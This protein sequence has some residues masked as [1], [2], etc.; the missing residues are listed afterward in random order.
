V[1]EFC[2][3][4]DLIGGSLMVRESRLVAA[5]MLLNASAEQWHHAIQVENQLQKR[6]PA[7]ARRAAQA[8]RKRLERLEPDFWRALRD[9]NEE[10]A[11]Q[12]AFCA[13]LERNLLLVEFIETVVH[14]AYV[15]RSERLE[16]YQW[17][18][19]LEER[20]HRDP[21]IADWTELSKKKMGQVVLRIP[22]EVGMLQ[23]TRNLGLQHLLVRPEVKSLLE[24][25]Y[26]YRIKACLGVAGAG[27]N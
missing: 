22:A 8:I 14:D 27:T 1:E 19:F 18:D 6:S 3:D 17:T 10:L 2:Y 25:H 11:T 24:D 15:T 7:S 23:S 21:A 20:V 5:L 4:S 13:A 12:V 9:G 26:K 16:P